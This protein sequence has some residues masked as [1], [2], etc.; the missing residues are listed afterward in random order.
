VMFVISLILLLIFGLMLRNLFGREA[1]IRR[2]IKNGTVANAVLLNIHYT[3]K[4]QSVSLQIQVYPKMGRN[5]LDRSDPKNYRIGDSL[6]IKYNPFNTKE[7]II[8]S[9]R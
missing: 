6:I 3:E 9:N 4:S 1:R 5:F 8:V 7:M 2:I